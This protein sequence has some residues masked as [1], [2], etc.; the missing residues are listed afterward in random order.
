[1]KVHQFARGFWEHEPSLTLGCKRLRP[2]A[3]K[4]SNTDTISPPHHPVTT[5]DLKSFIKPESASRKLGIGSSDDNT[6]KRDPSSP[7]GQAETH[8]PGGTRWNPTQEQIGI[9]EMLY[10]G[11]MRTPNAQQ[12]EQITAQL[13]KYGK[14]EGKNVFYWFQNHKARERQKQKRNNLG[15]AHSPRTTLTTSPPFSCCV[16]TTMDT[17][18][19][20]EVVEREEEDSPLKK[21]RS[22]AFEYLEDQR[23]EEHRTLELFPLHPEGR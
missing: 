10:R 11:G 22:W 2:L 6:N 7:Q 1:M 4:L 18:K 15:L 19:R 14:I 12:I 16:I 8:I 9:L 20:G 21:C 13:S 23:E 5:F 17:T 3:P